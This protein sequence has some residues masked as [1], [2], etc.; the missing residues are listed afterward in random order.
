MPLAAAVTSVVAGEVDSDRA[1]AAGVEAV[2]AWAG[3]VV[4]ARAAEAASSERI[5]PEQRNPAKGGD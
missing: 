5:D 1:G 3:V 2:A 4:A